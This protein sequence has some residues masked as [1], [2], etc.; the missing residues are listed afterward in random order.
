MKL[1][2]ILALLL[3][4][5]AGT[6][7]AGDINY[8]YRVGGAKEVTPLQ[9]FDDGRSLYLQMAPGRVVAPPVPF[10]ENGKPIEYEMRPPYMVLP[11]VP[12]LVL[13]VGAAKALVEAAD[14]QGAARSAGGVRGK[15]VWYGGAIPATVTSAAERP[16]SAERLVET[17]VDMRTL[18]PPAMQPKPDVV[19]KKTGGAGVEAKTSVPAEQKPAPVVEANPMP[20]PSPMPEVATKTEKSPAEQGVTPPAAEP[21]VKTG[22]FV[23]FDTEKPAAAVEK[24]WLLFSVSKPIVTSELE[25]VLRY[26]KP[27]I[28]ADGTAAG[29]AKAAS[30][31]SMMGGKKV[32]VKPRGADLGYIRISERG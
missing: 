27:V 20:K 8:A 29:Y 19:A 21:S 3:V 30:L 2:R 13:R 10:A 25:Q 6:A 12:R 31:R 15:N 18:P 5:A 32:V 23:V 9:V 22:R 11:M 1:N 26:E 24:S 14:D 4:S 17:R 28:E 16:V 7:G